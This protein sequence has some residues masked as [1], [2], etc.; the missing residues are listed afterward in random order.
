MENRRGARRLKHGK[1]CFQFS[2]GEE[3]RFIELHI[4]ECNKSQKRECFKRVHEHLEKDAMKTRV[5]MASSRT[6]HCRLTSLLG[7]RQY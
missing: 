4:G 1:C 2:E 6:S 7:F 5:R 3:G